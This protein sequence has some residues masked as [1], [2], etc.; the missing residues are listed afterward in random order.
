MHTLYTLSV[1][2]HVVAAC[3]WIGSMIFFAT[4]VV[5]VLRRPE[6]ASV[7]ADLVRLLGGR[8]RIIGWTSL[9]V[10]IGTGVSNLALRGIGTEQLASVTFWREGFGRTLAYKLA[11]VLLVVLC[12]AGHDVLSGSR[13]TRPLGQPRS[14][15]A[16]RA[17]RMASWLGRLTLLL[18]IVVILFA[19]WLVRGMPT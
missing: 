3:A 7:L 6:Y 19:V 11:A 15:A 5:P 4:A 9:V 2:V 12:T 8:F 17:R 10:L 1:F 18:S 16:M 14:P 13:A